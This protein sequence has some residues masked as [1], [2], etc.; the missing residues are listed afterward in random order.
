LRGERRYFLSQLKISEILVGYPLFFSAVADYRLRSY[1]VE[2]MF[3]RTSGKYKYFVE[4]FDEVDLTFETAQKVL[5]L[6]VVSD[7]DLVLKVTS[8]GKN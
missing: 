4:E 8:L 5:S 1:P 6:Y 7:P 2:H 3:S